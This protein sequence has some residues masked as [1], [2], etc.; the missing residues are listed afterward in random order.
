MDQF[1]E[2]KEKINAID[3]KLTEIR[4]GMEKRL[5][6]VNEIQEYQD[7][8]LQQLTEKSGT[9]DK[10]VFS[11]ENNILSGTVGIYGQTIHPLF[12]AQPNNVF[13]YKTGAGYVYKDV[14]TVTINDAGNA[15]FKN[16]LKHD[17]VSDIEPVFSYYQSNTITMAI[18]IDSNSSLIDRTFNVIE[19]A[20]FLPGSYTLIS[21]Y[22]IE[23][24]S[25]TPIIVAQNIEHAGSMRI[26][27]PRKM[28]AKKI[29]F[30]IKLNYMN[31]NKNAYPFGLKH[32]YLYNAY[33]G[34]STIIVPITKTNYI[35]ALSEEITIKD[36]SGIYDTTC[37]EKGIKLYM[38]YNNNT[39]EGQ[40]TPM[41][42]AN[43]NYL[44]QN[45]K[46]VYAQIPITNGIISLN[47][48][49]IKTR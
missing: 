18:E 31:G 29:V 17:T 25:D 38:Y 13:N 46:T 24:N 45:V 41:T 49:S 15:A 20:P 39:L 5:A 7:S 43:Q 26:C 34:E 30:A 16:I 6:V 19:M 47:F 48:K 3:D 23:Q 28:N 22:V 36:Q 12:L 4:S 35:S 11:D 44:S 14:A 33:I 21:A 32:V 27:L 2:A 1:S 42:A 9:N 40:I 37:S 8:L 10:I